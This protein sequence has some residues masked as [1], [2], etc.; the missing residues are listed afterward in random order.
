MKERLK[1]LAEKVKDQDIDQKDKDL[2]K[3]VKLHRPPK[4]LPPRHDLRKHLIEDDDL[5]KSKF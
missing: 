1:K 4:K 5:D 2:D 3:D